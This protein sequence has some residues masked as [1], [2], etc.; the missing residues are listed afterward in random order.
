MIPCR[1]CHSGL[2]AQCSLEKRFQTTVTLNCNNTHITIVSIH[3]FPY[4][5]STYPAPHPMAVE[6]IKLYVK[7]QTE[8]VNSVLYPSWAII[9]NITRTRFSLILTD[10]IKRKRTEA[11][12]ILC[13]LTCD[14]HMGFIHACT[15]QFFI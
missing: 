11:H 3:P 12:L 9:E 6:C 14:V 5:S 1:A 15:H 2:R 13:M 7:K 4:M 10:R 8:R